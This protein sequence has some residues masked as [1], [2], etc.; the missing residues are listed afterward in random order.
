MGQLFLLSDS[1]FYPIREKY[2]KILLNSENANA[3]QIIMVK[4]DNVKSEIIAVGTELLMG[5]VINTNAAFLS[6]ELVGLGYDV[7]HHSVVGDN[8]VRLREMIEL[9]SGRSELIILCGGI[10]PTEDD[11]TRDVLA[12]YLGETLVLDEEGD[13]K[14]K[15]YMKALGRRVTKNNQRQALKIKNGIGIQNPTGLAV[16]TFYRRG[17]KTY[18][19]LPGPPSELKPMFFDEVVPLLKKILPQKEFL[20]SRV[21]RFF[22]IGESQLV[23][24]LSELIAKQNNPT[25]A[26]YASPNEVR[27]RLTVKA[28]TGSEAM[29][30]LNR[31]EKLIMDKVG[32]YFYGY[33]EKNSL[34]QETIAVLKNTQQ[35]I[36][37]AESLTAGLVQSTLG[38]VPGASS[39]FLGGF[40]TYSNEMKMKLLGVPEKLLKDHGAVSRECA[41]AMAR[42]TQKKT[43]SDY[44]LS[45]T[46]VAG[47]TEVEG[48]KV[49][50]VWIALATKKGETSVE[51]FHFQRDRQYIQHSAMMNGLN[52]V[53]KH[54]LAAKNK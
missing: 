18:L 1:Q 10:G 37:V 50:T 26:P 6:E 41:L 51:E 2:V 16:G 49:G 13:K 25:I 52:M 27:L 35:S 20:T 42:Q 12:D 29:E 31:K 43:G 15:S 30:L 36:A 32:E 33:G 53:R 4:R 5:Q 45:L 8:S 21:L 14:I 40:V 17:N 3:M 34:A 11:I 47:P 24:E 7:Y 23:A 28:E 9:A 39:V 19:I 22:G 54:I 48:K 38:S 44:A 46:G